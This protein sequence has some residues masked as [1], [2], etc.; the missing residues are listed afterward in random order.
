[1]RK[2]RRMQRMDMELG[3]WKTLLLEVCLQFPE[4]NN[5][6]PLWSWPST[7]PWTNTSTNSGPNTRTN[8]WPR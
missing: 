5:G 3:K 1:M 8:T 2:A 4:N 6:L 7:R